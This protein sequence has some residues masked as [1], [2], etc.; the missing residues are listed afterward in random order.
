M[1]SQA[2]R[3]WMRQS[4]ASRV[5]LRGSVEKGGLPAFRGLHW[6]LD[7]RA[8]T[9]PEGPWS[10]ELYRDRPGESSVTGSG[11]GQRHERRSSGFQAKAAAV[12]G[13]HP[14]HAKRSAELYTRRQDAARSEPYDASATSQNTLIAPLPFS[15]AWNNIS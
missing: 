8:P 1:N 13:R 2:D 12:G 10:P 15:S 3:A 4:P 9:P 7:C 14:L 5:G 6:S 11:H